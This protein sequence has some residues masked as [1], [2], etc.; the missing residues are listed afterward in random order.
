MHLEE[1]WL[2]GR[3]GPS[4]L[5]VIES[6]MVRSLDL[7]PDGLGSKFYLSLRFICCVTSSKSLSP[8]GLPLCI[9]GMKPTALPQRGFVRVE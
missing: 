5:L 6:S 3:D 8:S 1:T 7:K 2:S 4:V 9:G